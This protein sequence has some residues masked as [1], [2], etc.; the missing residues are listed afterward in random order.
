[1]WRP[2]PRAD[3]TSLIND[4]IERQG[5]VSA[6]YRDAL[7]RESALPVRTY[8]VLH[9]RPNPGPS[10]ISAIMALNLHHCFLLGSPPSIASVN[11]ANHDLNSA[12]VIDRQ[13]HLSSC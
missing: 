11:P 12:I 4:L 1:V 7:P 10:S 8:S 2:K 5:R 13:V 9:L 6:P 3:I